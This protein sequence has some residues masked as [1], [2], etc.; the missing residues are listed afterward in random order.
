MDPTDVYAGEALSE[1]LVVDPHFGNIVKYQHKN[2]PTWVDRVMPSDTV[3]QYLSWWGQYHAAPWFNPSGAGQQSP[4]SDP[5]L[6]YNNVD[7]PVWLV[8][9]TSSSSND[10]SS[11]CV[12]LFDTHQH[13]AH[14]YPDAAGLGIGTNV[15]NTFQSTR[16]N[17]LRYNVDSFQLYE[18]CGQP[19][20]VAI[21]S[22][23]SI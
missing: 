13:E 1:V 9:M 17:I 20:W 15:Q 18:I 16:A 8:P 7:Q 11:T 3:N 2:V 5:Q 10:Q 21:Y 19:T 4:P 23:G 22:S 12:F 14:F 6:L